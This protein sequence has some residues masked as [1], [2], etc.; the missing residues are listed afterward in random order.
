MLKYIKLTRSDK[1]DL[2]QFLKEVDYIVIQEKL[3][4]A[5][6]SFK[7]ENGEIKCFSRNQELSET[8]NLRGF[9]Q[10]CQGLDRSKLNEGWIYFG[11]WLVPHKI[12][13]PEG[14]FN[15]FYLFDISFTDLQVYGFPILIQGIAKRA[16][17][18]SVPTLYR[19]SPLSVEEILS[20]VG[21]SELGGE[22]GE[23]IVIK[24]TKFNSEFKE[25]NYI[26]IVSNKFL[27]RKME[28]KIKDKSSNQMSE[29]MRFVRE[30]TT[31]ARVEK[32][33][34]KLVDKG[35]LNLPFKMEN[36]GELID[37]VVR[38]MLIDLLEEDS[39]FLPSNYNVED[40]SKALWKVTPLYI[41]R[42]IQTQSE[43]AAV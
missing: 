21:K 37:K 4:G 41:K 31:E 5:N 6:A 13:Y 30:F 26:K 43:Q 16:A 35:E 20:Y 29:E 7:L 3:D 23:G 33:L 25:S 15:Q 22:E 28:K 9:Y 42:I 12:Q 2:S 19:G 27:E 36:M 32:I 17:I 8:N 39:E 40:I 24:G 1:V 10:W 11:E 14:R 38:D 34:Y 18:E